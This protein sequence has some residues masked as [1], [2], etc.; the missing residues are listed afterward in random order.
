VVVTAH[1]A[2]LLTDNV[3]PSAFTISSAIFGMILDLFGRPAPPLSLG[4]GEY[5]VMYA[6]HVAPIVLWVLPPVVLVM[7]GAVWFRRSPRVA[8]FGVGPGGREPSS[9][10]GESGGG[11]DAE[12]S[13]PK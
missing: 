9:T 10:P 8:P 5:A 11:T 12:D 13:S 4:N 2:P 3:L 7:L 1:V 6:F